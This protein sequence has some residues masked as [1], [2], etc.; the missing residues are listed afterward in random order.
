[1]APTPFCWANPARLQRRPPGRCCAGDQQSLPAHLQTTYDRQHCAG[2]TNRNG[3]NP[4]VERP[5]GAPVPTLAP[6]LAIARIQP[7][8]PPS[9]S[10]AKGK[11]PA[12]IARCRKTEPEGMA[13]DY[14]LPESSVPP[15][16]GAATGFP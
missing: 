8:F 4:H 1:M 14:G 7:A 5:T 6:M 13:G 12:A 2:L 10:S 15:G 16:N 3:M 11:G 9:R